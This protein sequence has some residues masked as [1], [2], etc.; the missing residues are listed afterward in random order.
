[1]ELKIEGRSS[2]MKN[3]A[4]EEKEKIRER[5]CEGKKEEK[6]SLPPEYQHTYAF[7]VLCPASF[8]KATINTVMMIIAKH[9]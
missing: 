2:Y 4:L 8:L 7:D 5:I 1:M 9:Y 3:C 6:I